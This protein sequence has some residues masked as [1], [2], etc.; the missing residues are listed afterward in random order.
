[1]NEYDLADKV[2]LVTGG[3]RG[4][5]KAIALKLARN[6]AKV[7]VGSRRKETCEQVADE[8]AEAGSEGVGLKMDVTSEEDIEQ[9]VDAVKE[10]W[11][12]IDI[13][14]NNAG[15]FVQEKVDEMDTSTVDKILDVNLR[16]L[17]LCT[18]H[19]VPTMKEQ[20]DGKIINIGSIAS[21]VGFQSAAVYCA[22]KGAVANLTRELAMELGQHK[23]NVNAVA[24]GMID[25][26]MTEDLLEDE[27]TKSS[28]LKKIP[29]GR[30]GQPD[31]IANAVAFLASDE[32]EY[33]TGERLIID[34]GWLSK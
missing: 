7:A 33:I 29:Y 26:A 3:S 15:I 25:T 11:G 30:I 12:R 13:L 16:G 19:V 28:L 2:A 4:I 21:F 22:T 9:A 6:G 8:I 23:I 32:S 5:G 1:M 18:K 10:K 17:I 31:D 20:R 14:V 34:G 24:P 27:D